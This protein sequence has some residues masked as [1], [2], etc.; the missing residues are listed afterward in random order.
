MAAVSAVFALCRRMTAI[1]S[2]CYNSSVNSLSRLCSTSSSSSGNETGDV[3][4][5]HHRD[6]YNS[7]LREFKSPTIY[8]TNPIPTRYGWTKTYFDGGPLPRIDLPIKSLPE[9]KP[10]DAWSEKRALYGQN[11]YIDILGDGSIK[12]YET[13]DGPRWLMGFYGHEYA[14]TLR[15]LKF[16]GK[17]LAALKPRLAKDLNK[18][19]RYLYRNKNMSR[20]RGTIPKYI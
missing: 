20:K 10:K 8:K 12:P 17:K 5:S 7:G 6:R 13:H 15:R 11:D 18:R 14:R 3:S 2:N 16:T 9:Y 4:T 1:P 19:L